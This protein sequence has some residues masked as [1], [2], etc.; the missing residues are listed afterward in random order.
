MTNNKHSCDLT[1]EEVGLG[2]ETFGIKEN[3]SYGVREETINTKE[4]ISYEETFNINVNTSYEVPNVPGSSTR[5]GVSKNR[6]KCFIIVFIVVLMLAMVA[7]CVCIAS[8]IALRPES[9]ELHAPDC[10]SCSPGY[11][12]DGVTCNGKINYFIKSCKRPVK[13]HRK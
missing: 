3:V 1:Y 7:V 10:C 4:N 5:L 6:C 9:G 8:A 13:L 11:A 2:G 12:I